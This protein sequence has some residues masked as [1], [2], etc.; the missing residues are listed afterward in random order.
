MTIDE[1]MFEFYEDV[2]VQGP[3]SESTTSKLLGLITEIDMLLN[4]P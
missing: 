1:A 3:G 4:V 2:P